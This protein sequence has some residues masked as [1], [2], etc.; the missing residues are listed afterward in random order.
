MW[1]P[2]SAE[3]RLE[4]YISIFI[5]CASST[6][7]LPF[8]VKYDYKLN[9]YKYESTKLQKVRDSIP[10]HCGET[11]FG[12]VHRTIAIDVKTAEFANVLSPQEPKA[13]NTHIHC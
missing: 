12:N 8:K 3:G 2:Q 9:L 4:D 10:C 1:K 7:V 5:A 11:Q 13:S 6:F